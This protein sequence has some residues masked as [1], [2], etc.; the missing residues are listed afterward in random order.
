MVA[1]NVLA[2]LEVK[3][4]GELT[5]ICCRSLSV[6]RQS[7]ANCGKPGGVA[8]V[9]GEGKWAARGGGLIARAGA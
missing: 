7:S 2:R 9:L 1:G 8:S 6:P 3:G 5:G 4:R